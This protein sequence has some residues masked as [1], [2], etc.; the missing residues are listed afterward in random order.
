MDSHA[1]EIT[2]LSSGRSS[3]REPG[4]KG[5]VKKLSHDVKPWYWALV[6]H[7]KVLAK[8]G[9]A[10]PAAGPSQPFSPEW[11]TWH[12]SGVERNSAQTSNIFLNMAFTFGF[13]NVAI[14]AAVPIGHSKMAVNGTAT[15][16][17]ALYSGAF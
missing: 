10:F 11:R 1:L 8:S 16:M 14:P 2:E 7:S 6:S 15:S 4:L 9:M 5:L 13:I 17:L 12:D 3:G